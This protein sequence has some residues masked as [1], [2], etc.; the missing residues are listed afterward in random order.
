MKL[1]YA[2]QKKESNLHLKLMEEMYR[3]FYFFNQHFD[4]K[5][6]RPVISVATAGKKKALG[7]FAHDSWQTKDKDSM[8]EITI[9]AEAMVKGVEQ[10]MEI[11]I[12]EMAHMR[13]FEDK[14]DD[15]N[16]ETQRH[17]MKYKAAAEKFGLIVKNVPRFGFA[18]TEI[19]E[20]LRKVINDQFKP[21]LE[22][23]ELFRKQYNGKKKKEKDPNKGLTPVMIGKDTKQLIATTSAAMGMTQKEFT[24]NAVNSY[25]LMQERISE[26][27][28]YLANK[29]NWESMGF[30]DIEKY[31]VD[32]LMVKQEPV[33]ETG[34]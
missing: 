19:G 4:A 32:L 5:L 26:A 34:E 12:H 25:A 27:A 31:L 28:L 24:T 22:L 33:D 29:N 9:C 17:N 16:S 18:K 14:I 3:A 23:F 7:W 8:H 15:C 10:A 6:P 20:P 30:R 11:L 21:N 13:N 2:D 1:Y